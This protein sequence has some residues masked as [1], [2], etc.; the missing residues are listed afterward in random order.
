MR[1]AL[2]ICAAFLL[3]GCGL[4]SLKKFDPVTVRQVEQTLEFESTDF[5]LTSQALADGVLDEVE[6]ESLK[7]R[8]DSE[9][10][11]LEAWLA[12]EKAKKIEDE[13]VPQ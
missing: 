2:I 9:I 8:H 10:T 7:V 6:K 13:T 4:L 1:I 11:R 5:D 3:N 12:S